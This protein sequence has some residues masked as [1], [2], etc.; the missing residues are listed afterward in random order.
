MHSSV[1]KEFRVHTV[2]GAALSVITVLLI[3]YLFVSEVYFNF[4]VTLRERVHVNATSSRGLEMEFDLTLPEVPCSKIEID[5]SDPTGQAQ[6]LHLDKEHHVWKHRIRMGGRG[7]KTK[8]LLGSKMKLELGST[9]KSEEDMVEAAEED[10]KLKEESEESEAAL[11]E[12]EET[13]GSC[14]G[15][16]EEGECCNT[17]EDV[18][19]AYRR[20]GWVLRQEHESIE[21]CKGGQGEEEGEG[22]GC[23]VHGVVALSTGGGNLHLAPGR[24]A[25]SDGVTI[26]DVLMQSFQEW[27]V[28]HTIHK[29]R[30]GSEYPG[31]AYQLDGEERTI[32]DTYGMYQYYFQVCNA[33]K[34]LSCFVEVCASLTL[35]SLS[36]FRSFQLVTNS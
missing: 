5:A 32:Q 25:A 13:C 4:Q 33:E 1:S 36:N 14:Y 21:Q 26:L 27:N 24:R 9:L 15:A 29:I 20:K 6:S 2:Q 22:E 34:R 3:L 8:V 18:R 7:G 17:C 19:R 11:S 16:G 10:G 35:G 31:A 12:E 23:N 28:S 30:F